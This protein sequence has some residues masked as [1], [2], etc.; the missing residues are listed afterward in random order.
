MK[1][2][3]RRFSRK[4]IIS[5]AIILS[6]V[7]LIRL[8]LPSLGT[9]LVTEDKPQPS[10]II[11]VLMGSGPDRILGAVDLYEQ[12]YADHIVMVRNMV[13]GYDLVVSQGVKIPHDTDIA[14]E[15]A[16]Q[17]GVPA[18]K[19]TILPG[20]AL[21]TRDE[22]IAVREYLKGEPNINSLII[23]TSKYHSGR[24]K[25]IFVKAMSSIDR[26]IEVLS[27]PTEYDDFNA[28]KWWKSREDL[29]RGALEYL[30]LFHFYLRE[31]FE[32]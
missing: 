1:I 11:V 8:S 17:L 19:V 32:L 9:F 3:G 30:K 20:D 14:K 16:V 13:R 27:Y 18:E 29:K 24:A 25:K 10:D 31:Q 6:V 21:S 26:E 28:E 2:L 22:A 5:L 12:G 23:V 7:V 4:L 15:V